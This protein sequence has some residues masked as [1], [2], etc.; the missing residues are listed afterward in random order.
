MREV[1]SLEGK[2]GRFV[3][4]FLSLK[5][6]AFLSS[7]F[8]GYNKNSLRV[9]HSAGPTRIIV[10]GTQGHGSDTN[11]KSMLSWAVGNKGSESIW[12]YCRLTQS[13]DRPASLLKQ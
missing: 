5:I 9:Q 11:I 1:M 3:S 7:V 6:W 12:A 4:D 10:L 13:N 2:I 8:F